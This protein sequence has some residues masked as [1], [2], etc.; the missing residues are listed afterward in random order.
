MAGA[1]TAQRFVT[2]GV[3][4]RAPSDLETGRGQR[5][6]PPARI[7]PG[8]IISL[9]SNFQT[10]ALSA[11]TVP[12]PTQLGG[13]SL[14]MSGE[15]A[16][17]YFKNNTQINAQ[18]PVELI[19]NTTAQ[20]GSGARWG[21]QRPGRD[22]RGRDKTRCVRLGKPAGPRNRANSPTALSGPAVPVRAGDTVTVYLSGI[23]AVRLKGRDHPLPPAVEPFARDGERQRDRRRGEGAAVTFPLDAGFGWAGAGHGHP[24]DHAS[25][26]GH[27]VQKLPWRPPSKTLFISVERRCSDEGSP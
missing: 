23:G 22:R 19:P 7:S 18:A 4:A 3:K 26:V 15:T 13:L 14:R 9:R 11:D 8:A 16:P 10:G 21:I 5:R 6:Q 17:L 1:Q 12:P 27:P 20:R 24:A 25:G 2:G